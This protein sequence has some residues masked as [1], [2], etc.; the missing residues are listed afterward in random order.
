MG[1]ERPEGVE[2]R[3]SVRGVGRADCPSDPDVVKHKGMTA[4]IIPMDR[5]GIEVRPIKQMSGGASFNEVFFNDVRVPD[6]M[7]LGAVG[8]GWNVALTTLGFERDHS[9]GS[10]NGRVGGSWPAGARHRDERWVSPPTCSS[11]RSWRR[12]TFTNASRHSSTVD[13]LISSVA[14]ALRARR[15]PSTNCCGPR[16]CR[17]TPMWFRVSLAPPLIADT[18]AWGTYAWGEHVLGA[19]GYRIA[20][21]SDEIQRNIIAERVLAAALRAAGRQ[22][23]RM[24][25]RASLVMLPGLSS[26]T[27]LTLRRLP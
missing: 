13:S 12:R 6:S 15:V 23:R 8:D 25:K 20:G 17:C 18:G 14:A 22:G 1:G 16:V 2:F 11:A 10:H 7:R 24:A 26:A 5:P 3:S 21:G 4:F 9:G 27:N 19:P